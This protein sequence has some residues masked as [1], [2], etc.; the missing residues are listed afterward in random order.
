MQFLHHGNLQLSLSLHHSTRIWKV[1][2]SYRLFNMEFETAS[3]VTYG[4][5]E[6]RS[7]GRLGTSESNSWPRPKKMASK[8]CWERQTGLFFLNQNHC[9]EKLT[10]QNFLHLRRILSQAN[11][12]AIASTCNKAYEPCTTD[13]CLLTCSWLNSIK[14]GKR[15]TL[16]ILQVYS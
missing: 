1:F 2:E 13:L 8:T 3:L 11:F 12:F 15:K 16:I 6:N 14:T 7:W 4:V 10:Q 5:T 9:F